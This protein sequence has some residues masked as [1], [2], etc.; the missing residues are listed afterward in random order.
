VGQEAGML[1]NR[2]WVITSF[3]EIKAKLR[4]NP[5]NKRQ[6]TYVATCDPQNAVLTGYA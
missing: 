6:T 5:G 2:K 4:D 1:A 3:I